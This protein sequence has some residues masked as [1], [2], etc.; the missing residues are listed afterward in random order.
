V[1]V[2]NRFAEA[3]DADV[4]ARGSDPDLLPVLLAHA[5]GRTADDLAVDLVERR[6]QPDELGKGA[7][8]GR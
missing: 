4:R 8:R 3:L 6:L 7:D 2:A 5:A 1:D